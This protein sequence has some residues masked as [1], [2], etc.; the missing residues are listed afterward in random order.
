M[1]SVVVVAVSA[2]VITL[3]VR[4]VGKRN[5]NTPEINTEPDKLDRP[6]PVPVPP[7]LLP[8]VS[9][10]FIS[11][12]GVLTF[13]A[14]E[15]KNKEGTKYIASVFIGQTILG[16]HEYGSIDEA[17]EQ[18]SKMVKEY[19]KTQMVNGKKYDRIDLLKN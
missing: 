19:C 15:Q 17:Y 8:N 7:R 12:S 11:S 9:Y 5:T 3:V 16:S 4:K 14:I 2:V 6:V 13:S 1:A 10:S 18:Y